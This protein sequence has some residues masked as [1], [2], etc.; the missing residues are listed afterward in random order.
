[1]AK[2]NITQQKGGYNLQET[3]EGDVQN[4][5]EDTFI[6]PRDPLPQISLGH[7][8]VPD[9]CLFENVYENMV[10]TQSDGFRKISRPGT[11]P[12]LRYSHTSGQTY[13][14]CCC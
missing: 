3:F 9:I 11:A 13:I 14:S 8:L 6:N 2:L 10:T 1:M 12:Y 4:H 5:P 7:S